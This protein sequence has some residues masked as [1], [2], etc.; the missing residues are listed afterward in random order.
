MTKAHILAVG[1]T[2]VGKL[3]GKTIRDMALEAC[4]ELFEIIQIVPD[5][6]MV[7]NMS[8]EQF[9]GQSHL[10]VFI[11]DQLGFRGVPAMRIEAAC[12]SGGVGVHQAFSAI[13]SGLYDSILLI[14]IEK[15]TEVPT[16]DATRYLAGAADME[17]EIAPG[18]SFVGLNALIAQR[19]MYDYNVKSEDL[20][21]F[22]LNSHKNGV[23]NKKAM[24]QKEVSLEEAINSRIIADPLRLMDCS[25]VSD[26][27]AALLIV[28]DK[29]KEKYNELP[30]CEI[31]ASRYA[32]DRISLQDREHLCEL[33]ASK[34]AF[35][36]AMNDAKISLNDI[37]AFEI[38]DAFSIMAALS[39][40]SFGLKEKGKAIEL[41]K[42]EQIG[43]DGKYPVN[44]FG[45][46]KSRGHPVGATGVYQVMENYL[47]LTDQA[48]KNQV[49]DVNYALSQNIG[50]S[51]ATISVNICKRT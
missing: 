50:G 7:T 19:Y 18:V 36:E 13:K 11:T 43:L 47:Q 16:P 17:W 38:H 10:G 34:K 46:L 20:L 29:I 35:S 12:S 1:S 9:T 44:T 5:Q 24:F 48:G 26:G 37:K 3:T 14:G 23:T 42:D 21:L 33:Y 8:A 27:C 15:M 30:S 6:I 25:P 4:K 32:T 31:V 45:G 51:G 22:S 2:P 49:K 28:S 41:A 39:L 40:E